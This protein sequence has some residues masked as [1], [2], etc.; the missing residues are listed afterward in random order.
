MVEGR[1]IMLQFGC[2]CKCMYVRDDYWNKLVT[3]ARSSTYTHFFGDISSSARILELYIWQS[4]PF[5]DTET[6]VFYILFIITYLDDLVQPSNRPRYLVYY[7][8][9]VLRH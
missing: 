5:Y 2:I 4:V 3:M 1:L 6:Y 7:E 9:S 8:C